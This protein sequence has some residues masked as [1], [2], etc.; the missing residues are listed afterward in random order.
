MSNNPPC[1]TG[2]GPYRAS[3]YHTP[4][5][6]TM[7]GCDRPC[8][9]RVVYVDALNLGK[10]IDRVAAL[11]VRPDP[12]CFDATKRQ[13]HFAAQGWLIDVGDA[14]VDTIDELENGANV[15]RVDG[16]RQP[17]LNAVRGFEG[18]FGIRHA[19][20][21]QHRAEDLFARHAHRW[22]YAVENGRR[23]PVPGGQLRR[24]RGVAAVDLF[25]TLL[26]PNVEVM[27]DARALLSGDS[28]ADVRGLFETGPYLQLARPAEDLSE[29]SVGNGFD[30]DGAAGRRAALAGR[31][32]RA[33]DDPRGRQVEVGVGQH[34]GRVLAAELGLDWHTPR[35]T[36]R[37]DVLAVRL[38][39]RTCSAS[40]STSAAGPPRA[41][42]TLR[43]PS[44]KPACWN[45]SARRTAL[46]GV[47]EAGFRMTAL[48]AIRAGAIFHAGM[49]SGKFH[50]VMHATTPRGWRVVNASFDT[51]S[52]A[53]V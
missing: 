32:E 40:S 24:Q 13:V 22:L 51:D 30:D 35:R 46:A 12:R 16:C 28:R 45:S 43:T 3:H 19:D 41:A 36:A 10:K 48:P 34:D 31:A 11:L 2:Y 9:L 53:E 39:A 25:S 37:R 21:R 4:H 15:A 8:G 17:V 44:G 7:T 42:S 20:D 1:P 26:A 47:A 18:S 52:E 33:V 38:T 50:G 27:Q 14:D 23:E 29:E 6:E 49:A 5:G